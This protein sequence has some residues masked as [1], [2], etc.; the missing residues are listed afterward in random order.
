MKNIIIISILF[1]SLVSSKT[2]A[3]ELSGTWQFEK[4]K[5]YYGVKPDPLKK[6][7]IQIVN[8]K[9]RFP[10]QCVP[11]IKKKKFDYGGF[12][13]LEKSGVGRNEIAKYLKNNFD[14]ELTKVKFQYEIKIGKNCPSFDHFLVS[15]N[16]I[17]DVVPGSEFH[18]F[19]RSD[20]ETSKPLSPNVNLYGRKLSHLPFV[21][22]SYYDLCL[23]ADT[24]R[25]LDTKKCA[26][27]YYPYWAK[28]SDS[29][30][31]AQTIGTHNYNKY[32][33]KTA[34]GEGYDNPFANKL[35]PL[36]LLLPPMKDV[37]VALVTDEEQGDSVGRDGIRAVYVTIKDNKVIDQIVAACDIS[38]EYYCV[39][40]SGKK[41]YQIL[42]S[43]KFKKL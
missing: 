33:D 10:D 14:F 2:L 35:S 24:T 36:F 3:D 8:G 13:S 39:D 30:L 18:S 11:E 7:V 17:I 23:H 4:A 6:T 16:K 5:D 42:E 1:F 9:F 28:K 19:I 38:K 15:E 34:Q 22:E 43:G 21:R 40:D 20:G 32:L 41:L 12:Y 25:A 27:V 31:L 26:P 29:D 37:I